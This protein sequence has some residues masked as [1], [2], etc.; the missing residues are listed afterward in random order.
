M[1]RRS[2]RPKRPDEAETSFLNVDLD[3]FARSSLERL[4]AA[5]GSNVS[6]LYVGP[7][8]NRHGAHFE[9]RSSRRRSADALIVGLVQL[10][11]NLRGT[12]RELWNQADRRDFNIGIQG[13]LKPYSY[14]L[15][16]NP[17]TLKSVGSVN[18]R[19]VVTIYGAEGAAAPPLPDRS[20]NQV[21][22]RAL[23]P[24]TS[25]KTSKSRLRG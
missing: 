10:V 22:P 16:L 5:L 13:G 14:E 19:V 12:P 2:T 3:V 4:A 21:P 17:A 20:R 9:L 7:H 6:Q 1:K 18:A 15:S 8:G 11:K 24:L 23:Q 25:R